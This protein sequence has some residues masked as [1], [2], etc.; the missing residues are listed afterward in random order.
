MQIL[1]VAGG[2]PS[3]WPDFTGTD[4][5]FV[6]GIDRGN[7]F[8]LERNITPDLA[9]GDFDSLNEQE[10][11]Q[12]F[13][14]VAEIIT[15]PA[16]KDDTDTQLALMT[17]FQRFPE[18]EVT[19][20]GITGGRLDHLLANLWLALEE[21]FRPFVSQLYLK[22]KQNSLTYLK[23]G[24]HQVKKIPEMKYLAYVGLT[25]VKDLE[26]TGA[27]Y[28]LAKTSFLHP[29]SLSSNEF[30]QETAEV[31]FSEGMLA[32]IQSRDAE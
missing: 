18:A 4:F 15:S 22:D 11:K 28:E 13:A 21:R 2:D 30:I 29:V 1:L 3:L 7:L 12:V 14:N 32:V 24:N 10:K 8:L 23:P 16:E 27:K 20:I 26:L 17:T 25:A 31:A 19:L 5:S 9:I 6:V